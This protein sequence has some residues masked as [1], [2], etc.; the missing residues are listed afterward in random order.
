[1]ESH[2]Q[3]GTFTAN[4]LIKRSTQV[5]FPAAVEQEYKTLITLEDSNTY[6]HFHL[7][8]NQNKNRYPD[9]PCADASRVILDDK[10]ESSYIHA[11][12]V[13]DF[14]H[15]EK[16]MGFIATQA[17]LRTT[18]EDFWQMVWSENTQIIIML[19]KLKDYKYFPYWSPIIGNYVTI[20][21]FKITT[22][23][24]YDINGV[25]HTTLSM[26]NKKTI[27]IREIHHFC[28]QEWPDH[29]IPT[30]FRYFLSFIVVIREKRKWLYQNQASCG[31]TVVHCIGGVD[32]TGTFCAIMNAIKSIEQ[33]GTVNLF[34]IVQEIRN[35]RSQSINIEEQYLYCYKILVYYIISNS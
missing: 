19:M 7:P 2:F 1:M 11:N 32:K 33:T 28:Y 25:I 27:E 10:D 34:K 31:P 17:P 12:Y 35:R 4:E 13:F 8:E 16:R 3:L 30:N 14:N 15:N 9:I 20:G 26:K 21:K 18:V 5:D 24:F 6:Y 29:G 22:I 23:F